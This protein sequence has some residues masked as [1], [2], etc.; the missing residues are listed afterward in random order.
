MQFFSDLI[1]QARDMAWCWFFFLFPSS[2]SCK[3]FFLHLLVFPLTSPSPIFSYSYFS[4]SSSSNFSFSSSFNP[5]SSMYFF[6]L[7]P[8]RWLSRQ[9]EWPTAHWPLL[10]PLV[11]LLASR[12]EVS[13]GASYDAEERGGRQDH[14]LPRLSGDCR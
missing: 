4:L 3:Y 10:R 9:W 14:L 5:V 2:N 7:G 6:F 8:S 12:R 1:I 11:R 13:N